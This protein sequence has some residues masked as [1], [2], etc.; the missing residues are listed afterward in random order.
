MEI[1]YGTS[2]NFILDYSSTDTN[3]HLVE[4]IRISVADLVYHGSEIVVPDV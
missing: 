1:A 4:E 2:I 3:E